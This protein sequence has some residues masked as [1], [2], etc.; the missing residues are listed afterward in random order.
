MAD[1]GALDEMTL[2]GDA[3][4]EDVYWSGADAPGGFAAF[5]AR[6]SDSHN[7]SH[8]PDLDAFS[9]DEWG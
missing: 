1:A 8:D 3:D 2:H 9:E 6:H 5:L 4:K 7:D